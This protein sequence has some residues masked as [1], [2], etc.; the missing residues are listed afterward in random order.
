M[1][2]F[3]S[4]APLLLIALPTHGQAFK[5]ALA[6]LVE[7]SCIDCHD[8]DTKTQLNFEELGSDL[9]DE[10]TF[11]KW[12]KIFDR[13]E[14]GEMPPKKKKRPDPALKNKALEALEAGLRTE[15]LKQQQAHGRV[16][17]RRLTRLELEYTLQDILGV[18][19]NLARYLPP[20]NDSATFATVADK[21]GISPLHI[22][23]YLDAADAALDEAIELGRKPRMEPRLIDYRNNPYV[24]IWFERELRRGGDTVLRTDDAFVMFDGRPQRSPH[25]NQTNN[26][27]IQFP[28][29]GRY[30]I[31]AE[32]YAYQAKA[33]TRL[34]LWGQERPGSDSDFVGGDYGCR[35]CYLACECR[36]VRQ[37]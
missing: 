21:Q 23:N 10:V 20:E 26:M 33:P 17:V 15:N 37:A 2:R 16:P 3:I 36:E 5:D 12:V 25:T 13:V 28:V 18:R 6:P 32:A 31:V 27:G 14:K 1:N 29:A 24:R 11:S 34:D 7:A 4:I 8:A 19:G 35:Q 30:R 22:R 9:S